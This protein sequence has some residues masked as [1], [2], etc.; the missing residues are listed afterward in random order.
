MP[1]LNF[2]F[3]ANPSLYF[4]A[5]QLHLLPDLVLK[6]GKTL[7]LIMGSSSFMTGPHW[8]RLKK[9]LEKR[10]IHI[11]IARVGSEPSPDII[12]RILSQYR[13]KEINV[14][15][16]IGGGSVMDTGK[17]VSAMMTKKDSVIEYLEGVGTKV[18]DGEKIGFIAVPTTAGTGSEATK[19][20]VIAQLGIKGFKK[21]LRH[22]NFIPDIALVDP[23]LTLGTPSHIT[24]ACGMDAL[25]QL[26]ESLVST[27]ASPMTDSL[28]FSGLEIFGD[29]LIKAVISD[30]TDI[31]PRVNLS[32]ASYLSGLTLANAGLGIVHGFAS[33]IGGLFDIPHGVV[34][35]TLLARVTEE[36]ISHLKKQVPESPALLKYANASCLIDVS[37]LSDV[38]NDPLENCN[39]LINT[40]KK[41]TAMLKMPSLGTY[42]VTAKDINPIVRATGQKNNPVQ[43]PAEKLIHILESRL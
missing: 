12:D 11:H 2:N 3:F 31:K 39:C 35:G 36:T 27:Q 40:L 33:G 23:E 42:G 37:G 30:S 15:A 10:S 14:V 38:H 26:L 18:H 32:Y 5:G 34:C 20:A 41:W 29:S 28:A 6:Y 9:A 7:L 43:L 16:A 1:N 13:Q 4:G 22:D 21:S 19:N 25:T 24:A 17:A 8:P